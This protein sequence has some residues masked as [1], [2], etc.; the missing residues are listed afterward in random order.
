[1]LEIAACRKHLRD[2]IEL[3]GRYLAD[4]AQLLDQR[5]PHRIGTLAAWKCRQRL[6]HLYTLDALEQLRPA[7]FDEPGRHLWD[8]CERGE[9][10]RHL[11]HH[12]AQ[13]R[14]VED[15]AARAVV[16]QGIT[17][18]PRGERARE[19]LTCRV[20]RAQAFQ[21]QP[22]SLGRNGECALVGERRELLAEPREPSETLELLL[23]ACRERQ[24]IT[25]VIERV[26]DLLRRQ[27]AARPVGARVRFVELLSEKPPHRFGI[28]HL[29]RQ[30]GETCGDLG[31]E[32]R[33]RE[34]GHRQHP[35]EIL[36]RGMHDLQPPV[37]D[38]HLRER[39]ET[40]ERQ[41]IDA[42]RIVA[43]CALHQA[44][45][46]AVRPR[47]QK[48]GVEANACLRR[49]MRDER[50]E[51][52]RCGDYGFQTGSADDLYN[53]ASPLCE[54]RALTERHER[55]HPALYAD[56]AAAPGTAGPAG[57]AAA[58]GADGRRLPC[59]EL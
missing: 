41:R 42:Q 10:A 9:R 45:L 56:R 50:G 40:P 54:A 32:H 59:R 48:L 38:E 47:T 33:L 44:Q 26:L 18:A 51:F 37:R 43:T 2:E 55:V 39:S 7:P 28:A 14:I 1:L 19:A 35:R 30:P 57:L 23:Q 17:L 4:A 58:A 5:R 20:E 22:G 11:Q 8:L 29:R 12:L 25:H 13:H 36:T 27:R 46:S 53:R 15:P 3:T 24:Q 52:G 6:W 49:E 21:T 31:V 16:L 34:P